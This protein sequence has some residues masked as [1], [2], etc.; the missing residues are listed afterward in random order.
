MSHL[1]LSSKQQTVHKHKLQNSGGELCCLSYRLLSWISTVPVP[2]KK[3]CLVC[4]LRGNGNTQRNTY[5]SS[6]LIWENLS[7][8]EG[9]NSIFL[10]TRL[11]LLSIPDS[12]CSV[13]LVTMRWLSTRYDWLSRSTVVFCAESCVRYQGQARG[14]NIIYLG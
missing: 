6:C 4:L 14:R 2:L 11:S 7:F 3:D 12:N 10:F 8:C 9:M 1:L 5:V 13:T